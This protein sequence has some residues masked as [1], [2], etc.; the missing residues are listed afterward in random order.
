MVTSGTINGNTC[1]VAVIGGGPAGSTLAT[2]LTQSGLH[3]LLFEREQ[4]PRFHVGESLLPANLPIFDRLGCHDTIRKMAFLVKPGATFYD[5]YEG[6]GGNTFTFAA[7]PYQPTF[8]YNVVRAVFDHVLLQHAARTGATVC[9]QHTVEH[10]HFGADGVVV[11]VRDPHGQVHTIQAQLLV[12]ASGRTAFCGSRRGKREPLPGL[13]R[14]ALF[15]HFCGV[16]R[17]T[18]VPAGNIRIY[19]VRDGWLWWI[20]FADGTDSIGCVLHARAA[21]ERPGSLTALFEATLALSPRLAQGLAGARRL[22]P[23][24][25][26]ANF[27]YRVAPVVAD[28]FVA[29]G[30]AA[31]FLDPIFSTGVFIAMRSAELAATTIQRAFQQQDFRRHRLQGYETQLRRGMAPFLAFIRHFYDPACLDVLFAPRPPL[32]T[33]QAVLWVLSGAAFD[34]RPL[35]VQVHLAFFRGVVSVRKARRWLTGLSTQS[36]WHW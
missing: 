14:V 21:K 10:V 15:A 5:E 16:H 36:R 32:R 23:V 33:Y 3:V 6:R 26:A 2:L 1:D 12:D 30:D 24:H 20:P 11:Q 19:L 9:C 18:T 31:G 27:S 35:W 29:I 34:H 13:G 17:D 28:R 4:F 25:T 8:A 22:T 7:I